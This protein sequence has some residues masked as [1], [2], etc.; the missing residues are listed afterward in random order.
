VLPN[1][2]AEPWPNCLLSVM[3]AGGPWRHILGGFAKAER[4]PDDEPVGNCG[5]R[6]LGVVASSRWD[7]RCYTVMDIF[8][9]Q[10][11]YSVANTILH[12]A[13]GISSEVSGVVS[14]ANH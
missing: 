3:A 7:Y 2:E 1:V 11:L 5:S 12:N 8:C 4:G 13:K 9:Q 6:N 10:G 14:K